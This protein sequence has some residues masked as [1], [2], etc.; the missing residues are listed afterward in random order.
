[1]RSKV[2]DMAVSY[3]RLWKLLADKKISAADLRKA[4]GVAPNTMT[5]LRRDE[6]VSLDVLGR[7]CGVLHAD[8]GDVIEYIDEGNEQHDTGGKSSAD[9]R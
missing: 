1:M 4:S 6:E 7:I 2:I 9:N 3:R 8:F 5:R